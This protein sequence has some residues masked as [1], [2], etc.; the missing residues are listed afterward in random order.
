EEDLL[1]EFNNL[2]TQLLN[3]SISIEKAKDLAS[4]YLEKAKQ[5]DN[6]RFIGHV[7]YLLALKET[8]IAQKLEDL[9]KSI[10]YTKNLKEDAAF[11][12]KAYFLK[13]AVLD[14]DAKYEEALENYFLALS[15]AKKNGN[16]NYQNYVKYNIAFLKRVI[17][18][19]EEALVLFTECLQYE[20]AEK[21]LDSNKYVNILLLLSAVNFEMDKVEECSEIN[22][23]GIL[24]ARKNNKPD[25]YFNFVV[26]EGINLTKKGAYKAAI[27]SL[28]KGRIHLDKLNQL[29][30]DY[31]L[32]KSYYATNKK[33][34]ALRLFKKIDTS[35]DA[36]K[37]LFIPLRDSYFYLIKDAKQKKDLKL[38]LH[39][40]NRLIRIDS[41]IHANYKF[42]YDN[43]KNDYDIPQLMEE[44]DETIKILKENN[45]EISQKNKW[46]II[47]SV[48]FC[49]LM[50]GG[51]I[52]NYLLKKKY[53]K[54]YN[55]IMSQSNAIVEE[56][57]I[58][59]NATVQAVSL[60]IDPNIVD[61]VLQSLEAFERGEAYLTNQISLKDVAKI[62]NT[63]SKYLSKIVNTY[64]G[65]N[66]TTYINDLR[67][68]YLVNHV[69]TDTK[70][71]KYTI[72]AIAEEIGFSNPEGFSRAF[73]KKT[74]LKPS[75]FIKKVRE[76]SEKKQ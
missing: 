37:R 24:F 52:Y 36:K 19:Y 5:S 26:H 54:R 49:V 67:I 14:N 16:T 71:Q 38:Q 68:D 10:L 25:F 55:E 28:E 48:L 45:E 11:P 65:K 34:K 58:V 33:E 60:G 69:Q 9:D 35:F 43:I 21:T 18:K 27:D 3:T 13:G 40:T 44:R 42:L 50:L 7:Y 59:K 73:Q 12:M 61:E 66:F 51:F 63:N 57:I 2:R 22:K 62:V 30:A 56:E 70:Y 32:A 74:G 46:I 47:I 39:Y 64:K 23:K 41:I 72:R 53:E 4:N 15:E 75:Y 29:T 76:N 20:K 6:E 17:G 8:N 31:Y 1:K